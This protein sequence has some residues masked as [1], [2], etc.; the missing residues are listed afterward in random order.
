MKSN[1]CCA[2]GM[3]A[4]SLVC[5]NEKNASMQADASI[6]GD[7]SMDSAKP[8]SGVASNPEDLSVEALEL[9]DAGELVEVG[10]RVEEGDLSVLMYALSR[11]SQSDVAI[12]TIR[13]PS[14]ELIYELQWDAFDAWSVSDYFA[15]PLV[16]LGAAAVMLPPVPGMVLEE[17]EYRVELIAP[18]STLT[19]GAVI[20]K[21]DTGAIS[22]VLNLDV[23]LVSKESPLLEAEALASFLEELRVELDELL[24]VH[25]MAIGEIS[26]RSASDE[27]GDQ[28]SEV[29]VETQV[30]PLCQAVSQISKPGRALRLVIVDWINYLGAPCC[31]GVAPAAPGAILEPAAPGSC[32]LA[33]YFAYGASLAEQAANFLH[34]GSHFMGMPHTTEMDGLSF[35]KYPDTPECD[36]DSYDENADEVVD[37]FECGVE[38]GADNYLFYGGV[39][40]MLP[41]YISKQQAETLRVHPL[42][43]PVETLPRRE[44]SK[45]QMM[46]SFYVVD[47]PSFNPR[48][49]IEHAVRKRNHELVESLNRAFCVFER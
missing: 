32:V 24:N 16:G 2:A 31:G 8:D 13:D 20:R 33:S 43:I 5:C 7:A 14:G 45:D 49:S 6:Q 28:Y 1:T 30:E 19:S 15:Y 18:D 34:E 35:D 38:G 10:L 27:L 21:R 37:D 42:F 40:E 41:Y 26:I 11:D 44:T 48:E 12:L 36:Q 39:P 29:D 25:N 4:L 9:A 47:G 23:W 46:R 3:L 22:F 17:G